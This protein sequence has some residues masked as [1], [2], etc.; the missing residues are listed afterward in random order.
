LLLVAVVAIAGCTEMRVEGDAKVFQSSAVAAIVRTVIG[1]GLIG[2]G[3][4]SFVSS[5]LPDRKPP[6]RPLKPEDKLTSTQRTG[7][8]LFGFAMSALGLGLALIP[9][10]FTKK[11]HVSVY[12]DRVEMASSYSQ[13]GGKEVVVP[14]ADI[15]SVEI[16]DEPSGMGKF[17]KYLVFGTHGGREIKQPASNNEMQSL[18]T[19]QAA[20]A[21]FQSQRSPSGTDSNRATI[22]ANGPVPSTQVDSNEPPKIPAFSDPA[23]ATVPPLAMPKFSS[24]LTPLAPS[25]AEPQP[26][27]QKRS[28][29]DR[30]YALKRYVI[31]IPIPEDRTIVDADTVVPI[32]T[33]LEACYAGSWEFVTVVAINDDGTITCNWDKWKS[34]TYKM[35]RE[36]LIIDKSKAE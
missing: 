35:M 23:V 31:N 14:F 29:P 13:T 21:E 16:R 17:Q 15:K 20:L 1:I 2:L 9:L 19:I 34:F 7:L 10:L 6:N 18:E 12:P 28:V 8:A 24:D 33:K 30:Q 25:V 27:P 36:D 5:V 22:A 11:L 26:E 4:A 32:G 3:V